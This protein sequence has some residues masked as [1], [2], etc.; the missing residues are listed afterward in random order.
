MAHLNQCKGCGLT[1]EAKQA[2]T[3]TCCSAR[4]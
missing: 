3:N 1:F 4:G 2:R